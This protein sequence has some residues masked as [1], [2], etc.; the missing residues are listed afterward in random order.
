MAEQSQIIG[1]FT[2]PEQVREA[3]RQRILQ[4]SQR[5]GTPAAQQMYLGISQIGN[6][7]FGGATPEMQRARQ[8]QEIM[9]NIA[10]PPGTSQYYRDLAEQLRQK[11]MMQAALAAAEKARAVEKDLMDSATAKYGA[12][13]FVQYGSQA[14][15]IRR[16]IMQIER[17]TDPAVKAA[18]QQQLEEAFRLGAKEV[19]DRE[20]QEAGEVEAAKLSEIRYN[21]ALNDI[22]DQLSNATRNAR[23]VYTIRKNIINNIQN[24]NTGFGAEAITGM[25]AFARAVGI[26][27]GDSRWSQLAGNTQA[28]QSI[29]GQLMLEQIKNLGTNPSNADREFLMKTLP[30]VTN[31]PEAIEKIASF[32]EEKAKFLKA[33]AEAK[34]KHLKKH[35]SLVD[36]PYESPV[37]QALEDLYAEANV[38]AART[39][40]PEDEFQSGPLV[41]DSDFPDLTQGQVPVTTQTGEVVT[42][43]PAQEPV[44]VQPEA[45]VTETATPAPQRSTQ[46]VTTATAEEVGVDEGMRTQ[47]L[48]DS[49]E[50]LD[51]LTQQIQSDLSVAS[52][53]TVAERAAM[54]G[55]LGEA[56]RKRNEL[57]ANFNA[58][59]EGMIIN[60]MTFPI[61]KEGRVARMT[62]QQKLRYVYN[63]LLREYNVNG[64]LTP[65]QQKLQLIIERKLG[66]R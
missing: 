7:L 46:G 18:L 21:K 15:N 10:S 8:T 34:I 33:D 48:P 28:A 36:P 4:E 54:A 17:T 42:P 47:P 22:S 49:I 58:A 60:D 14:T 19:A 30:A 32:L 51:R 52:D 11:G 64:Q 13:S 57:E 38:V 65:E 37:W 5:F 23:S 25:Q 20:A 26:T 40:I 45:V 39:P 41:R 12:I 16:L 2:S 66:M 50:E 1:L 43:A 62:E 44:V 63:I 29:I 9:S 56:T 55:R 61:G 3:Q 6:T 59:I 27:E 35:K 31:Q 53:L 24:I